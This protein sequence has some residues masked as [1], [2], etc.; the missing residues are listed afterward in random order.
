VRDSSIHDCIGQ[1]VHAEYAW[2]VEFTKNVFYNGLK[3]FITSEDYSDWDIVD[4]VFL[5][6]KSRDLATSN[7]NVYDPVAAIYMYGPYNS[8]K[9]SILV[10][11]NQI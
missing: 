8:D 10:T 9:D 1:C 11:G 3:F 2:H 7:I 4:N 5:M 6:I